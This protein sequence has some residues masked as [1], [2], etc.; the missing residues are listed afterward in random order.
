MVEGM[1]ITE[2][3]RLLYGLQ[4]NSFTMDLRSDE[5]ESLTKL[6]LD[7]LLSMSAIL[8]KTKKRR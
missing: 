6:Y 2:Q 4:R 7:S 8:D 5:I 1:D 3:I